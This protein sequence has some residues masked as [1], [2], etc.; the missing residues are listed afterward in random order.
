MSQLEKLSWTTPTRFP[1]DESGCL[2]DPRAREVIRRLG[3]HGPHA[4]TEALSALRLAAKKIHLAMERYA[5]ERGLSEGR[6]H[7]VMRLAGQPD[8]RLPLGDLAEMLEV[9]PRTITGLIDN[10]ER[11]GWVQRLPDD[12]DRRSIQAELTRKGLEQVHL[13]RKDVRERQAGTTTGLTTDELVQLR[14]LC[15]RLVQNIDRTEGAEHAR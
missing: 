10:L 11:D 2:Y 3:G 6:I 12:A 8:H 14:H 5:E 9:A 15:L 13:I 7:I 1:T 4:T